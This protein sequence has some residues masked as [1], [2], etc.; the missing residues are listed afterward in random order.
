M[1]QK[2]YL[3]IVALCIGAAANCVKAVTAI[4]QSEFKVP[5]TGG[6]FTFTV[7]PS[8]DHR[9]GMYAI[10][11]PARRHGDPAKQSRDYRPAE[12][13]TAYG[14]NPASCKECEND[15]LLLN[16]PFPTECVESK[17]FFAY[18]KTLQQKESVFAPYIP[19]EMTKD[20]ACPNP[21]RPSNPVSVHLHEPLNF[22]LFTY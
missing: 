14:C 5:A 20:G 7:Y 4:S 1:K 16:E 15:I 19:I 13:R 17:P 22:L 6:T 8:P 9:H 3:L 2:I 12:Q 11:A 10:A 21:D 18:L